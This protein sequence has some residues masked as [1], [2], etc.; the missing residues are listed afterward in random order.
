[1]TCKIHINYLCCDDCQD[2]LTVC[3]SDILPNCF[4][5]PEFF[6]DAFGL[7]ILHN[8]CSGCE[9]CVDACQQQAITV[10]LNVK[11]LTTADMDV[12]FIF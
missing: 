1:M 8:R 6:P 4:M 11:S 10:D 3:T 7:E 9:C 2:C 12:H 5:S